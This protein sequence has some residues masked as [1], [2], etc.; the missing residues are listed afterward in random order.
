MYA[1]TATGVRIQCKLLFNFIENKRPLTE[2]PMPGYRGYIPRIKT[3]E[4]GLGC[5]Y[6]QTTKKG[7]E[8]FVQETAN[9]ARV[10]GAE[11][12]QALKRY[13]VK[14]SFVHFISFLRIFILCI[15]QVKYEHDCF[16]SSLLVVHKIE[17]NIF[18]FLLLLLF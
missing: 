6:N 2:P 5:R 17:L 8:M 4:K 11:I 1:L 13:I 7:L 15:S 9:H 14:D 3:T 16:C 10:A 12:P 18:F